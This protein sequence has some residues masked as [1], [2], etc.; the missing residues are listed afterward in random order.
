MDRPRPGSTPLLI[1]V[2]PV[3]GK[4]ASHFTL[5]P[6]GVNVLLKFG[7]WNILHVNIVILIYSSLRLTTYFITRESFKHIIKGIIAMVWHIMTQMLSLLRSFKQFITS[8]KGEQKIR[9]SSSIYSSTIFRLHIS[10]QK[11]CQVWPESLIWQVLLY[12]FSF[13]C[14]MVFFLC[15]LK[16]SGSLPG[17]KLRRCG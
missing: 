9:L 13:H 14:S 3:P 11:I 16:D 7:R 12:S 10:H 17:L 6:S 2:S 8:F 1:R 5:L 4:Y 15:S